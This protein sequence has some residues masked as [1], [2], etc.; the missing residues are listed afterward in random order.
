MLSKFT[1]AAGIYCV[2]AAYLFVPHFRHFSTLQY[3]LPAGLCLAALGCFILSRRWVWTFAGSFFAG[4]IYGFGPF[5]LGLTKFHPTVTIL[6]AA[7]PWLF[8]P[9]AFVPKRKWR[10]LS[11]P[12]SAV[13]FLAIA[14][15]FNL[16]ASYRLFPIPTQA[17][18]QLSDTVSLIAPL[19]MVQRSI[20]LVGFYHI[21]IATIIVGFSM[22]LAARRTGILAILA[23]GVIL[24][25]YK[26]IPNV[27]PVIWFSIPVL[28]CSILVGQGLQGLS[29]AGYA[30][31][32]LVL[33]SAFFMGAL[34]I[35]TL[36]WATR[37]FE[38]FAGMGKDVAR[39]FAETA[40]FY[41]LGALAVVAI[42]FMARAKMRAT[43][44]RW[45]VLCSA[46]AVDIFLG[47]RFIID[48][49]L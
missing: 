30:D 15:F 41:I 28:C 20:A 5:I 34:A 26:A 29:L 17:S 31:R 19:V 48:S 44:L 45:I 43:F 3:F 47:A 1:L 12:L 39:L 32:K 13:P 4:A 22:L 16:A 18:M 27:S 42:F 36:L 35:V 8:L 10:W 46:M 6:T 37:Y 49:V 7:I 9:A 33:L 14:L 11:I 2:F 38:V 23:I 21:P 24:S 25:F 40:K